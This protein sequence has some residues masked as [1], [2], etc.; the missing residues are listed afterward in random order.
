MAGEDIIASLARDGK[1]KGGVKA[2]VTLIEFSNFQ[3]SIGE[4]NILVL[5]CDE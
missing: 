3:Y 4:T 1:G 5:V 2:L